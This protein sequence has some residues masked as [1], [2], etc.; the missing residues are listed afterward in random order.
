[1]IIIIRN[2]PRHPLTVSPVL[3]F[4]KLCMKSLVIKM[5]CQR[6][7]K[8]RETNK[9]QKIPTNK[10]KIR[11][12]EISQVHVITYQDG[13]Q[14]FGLRLI[15]SQNNCLRLCHPSGLLWPWG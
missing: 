13:S 4:G 15:H 10:Q 11:P 5:A 3:C 9:T 6:G 8:P 12:L 2:P 1:M 7:K 14:N